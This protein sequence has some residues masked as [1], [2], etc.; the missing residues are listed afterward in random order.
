MCCYVDIGTV[1]SQELIPNSESNSQSIEETDLHKLWTEI[2]KTHVT[3]DG[4]VNYKTLQKDPEK[5]ENYISKLDEF[6]SNK[7]IQSLEKGAQLA[8][9]INAYNAFTVDLIIKHYP[10]TSIKEIKNPWKQRLWKLGGTFYNLKEIEHDI[11]R[12]RNEPRIHFAIVCASYS[13]PKLL[14]EAYNAKN[15]EL[16]LTNASKDFLTDQRRNNIS[17]YSLKISKIF[18]WFAEDFKQK[19]SLINFL[20]AYSSIVISPT[21]NISYQDYNWNLNE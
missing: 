21:A 2:L 17:K 13:C 4:T 14:N 11:L 7:M 12:K 8:F 16:Q 15:I 6:C 10:V 9:W 20:N 5:L 18:D 3:K 1:Q 19:G